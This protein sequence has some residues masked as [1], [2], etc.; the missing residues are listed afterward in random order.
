MELAH[1]LTVIFNQ[2]VDSGSL[3]TEWTKGNVTPIYKKS[4]KNQAEN[5]RP[6]SLTCVACKVLEHIICSQM[7]KHIEQHEI[8]TSLQHGFRSMA[9]VVDDHLR[10]NYWLHCLIYWVFEIPRSRTVSLS[11]ILASLWLL[12]T[13]LPTGE[14]RALW[15]IRTRTKHDQ[16]GGVSSGMACLELQLTVCISMV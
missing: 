7:H 13:W 6:V 10:L 8:L 4:N 16:Y 9:S 14:A 11:S 12:A 5:Y 2:S 3:P 1:A 15:N